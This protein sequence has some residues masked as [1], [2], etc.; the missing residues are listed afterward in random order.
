MLLNPWNMY[1]NVLTPK[2]CELIQK[3]TK[4]AKLFNKNFYIWNIH[5]M[6][7]ICIESEFQYALSRQICKCLK[8]RALVIN[9]TY[10]EP[11]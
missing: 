8:F 2:I 10:S 3:I 4:F 11:F 6:N 1:I 7:R 9:L 5:P